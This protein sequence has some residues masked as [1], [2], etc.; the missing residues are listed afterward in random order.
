MPTWLTTIMSVVAGGVLTM[1]A[2]WLGDRRIT[3]RDRER[4]REERRERLKTRRDDFQ[5][6]TLLA[7]QVS[8][9]KLLRNAGASLHQDVV[10]HRA[11]GIWQRQQLPGTLADDQ[12]QLSTEI[13]LLA[14][15]IRDDHVRTL[16]GQLRTTA[17]SV[18]ASSDETE[19]EH[20]MMAAATTQQAL[21]DR[22]GTLV[23]EMD[24]AD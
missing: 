19:A 17:D 1:F 13:M 23:R 7:L 8:S 15:R 18:G 24:D 10:A 16:A 22:I 12:L 5:R 6:D 3:Q 2:A 11:T 9:Q 21:I 4:R 14:S 20:R